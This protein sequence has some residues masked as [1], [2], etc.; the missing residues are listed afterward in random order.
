M[1]AAVVHEP[2]PPEVLTVEDLPVPE[3]REGWIVV[4]VRAFGLNRSELVTRRGESGDAVTFPRVLGIE[5]TGV[6]A[7]APGGEFEEGHQVAAMMG[8]MGRSFDG[9]Y[10][11][12][13]SVPAGQVIAFPPPPVNGL[14]SVGGFQY[15]LQDLSGGPIENLDATAQKLT[16]AANQDPNLAGVFTGFRTNS[17]QLLVEVDRERA[18]SL[19]VDITE[20]FSTMSI[21][22]GSAYVNNFE[23]FNRNYRVYVQDDE[24]FRSK[25]SDL[26]KYYVRS[27][28]NKMIPLSNVVKITRET[29]PPI[30]SHYNL[31]RSVE[32]NGNAK[33]GVSSGQAIAAMENLSK[34]VLPANMGYEWSGL[35]LEELS[36]EFGVSRERIRQIEG[37]AFEKVQKAVTKAAA[38][39]AQ[40]EPAPAE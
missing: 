11:E 13:T 27:R 31:F 34:Q 6:V 2:G 25:P 21:N 18:K 40:P 8:G 37:R 7:A 1:K 4:R 35:S 39:Q 32:I 5:A 24:Q 28:D 29:A 30:I 38:A 10:A 15:E 3:A 23:L 33:P 20:I 9:G 36:A 17:P 26:E 14:G 12:F 22:F 19:N 16:G